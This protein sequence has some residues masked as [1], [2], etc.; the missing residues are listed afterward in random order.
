MVVVVGNKLEE[1]EE[2]VIPFRKL[3]NR[4]DY[5]I[6]IKLH[7]IEEKIIVLTFPNDIDFVVFFYLIKN[8]TYPPVRKS[9]AKVLGWCT[10]LPIEKEKPI[11]KQAMIYA[12]DNPIN[13][14]VYLTTQDNECWKVNFDKN[15][16]EP[17]TLIQQFSKPPYTY[18][19]IK[20]RDGY[21][22][23]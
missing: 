1:V 16:Y 14:E 15:Q 12:T 7:A 5:K 22:L 21:F 13:K 19:D 4:N 20:H 3:Y 8:L 18:L 2:I 10:L 6:D 17:S 23:S 9:M 11:S